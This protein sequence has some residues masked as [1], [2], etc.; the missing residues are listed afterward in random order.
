MTVVA[1]HGAG[2]D[3]IVGEADQDLGIE[4]AARKGEI[5]RRLVPRPRQP[6]RAP[7]RDD[8]GLL[9][10]GDGAD[11]EWVMAPRIANRTFPTS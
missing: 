1:D 2:N 7:E 8:V 3:A 4:L 5:A 6:A 10:V 9:A 11:G